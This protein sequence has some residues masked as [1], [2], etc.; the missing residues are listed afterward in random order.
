[1]IADRTDT[2]ERATGFWTSPPPVE[3]D[4]R[5]R[6]SG[7][8]PA[9][10]LGVV[11]AGSS[12]A[13]AWLILAN[14]G[15]QEEAP[16]RNQMVLFALAP[17]LLVVLLLIP[18]L[19][20]GRWPGRLTAIRGLVWLIVAALLFVMPGL[21]LASMTLVERPNNELAD[22]PSTISTWVL[23]PPDGPSV[24]A[25]VLAAVVVVGIGF[26]VG[27]WARENGRAAAIVAAGLSPILALVPLVSYAFLG[28]AES[29]SA[30]AVASPDVNFLA[31]LPIVI[32]IAAPAVA[33]LAGAEYWAET[34]RS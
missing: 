26:L 32:W 15:V 8:I 29:L 23:G 22:R 19:A 5:S 7:I 17:A 1:M 9:L 3:P 2:D 21:G 10:L 20:I 13:V 25:V 4:V 14:P 33:V 30:P 24:F 11:V 31:A 6:W 28:F 16:T 27:R 34:Y 18:S 12:V